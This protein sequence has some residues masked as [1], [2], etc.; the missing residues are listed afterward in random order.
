MGCCK[1]LHVSIYRYKLVVAE[2]IQEK[3]APLRQRVQEYMSEPQYIEQV[4]HKGAEK[5]SVIAHQTWQDVKTRIGL[6]IV[7]DTHRSLQLSK[8]G[9]QQK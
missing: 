6:E 7:E 8:K 3:L 2:V 5:A 9:V 1:K 4:L